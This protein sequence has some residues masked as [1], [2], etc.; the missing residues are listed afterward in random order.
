MS[1]QN[2]A[3]LPKESSFIERLAHQLGTTANA[4][5]IYGEPVE[6]DGVTV[7]PVAKAA[8]GFGGGSG[9]QEK[10]EGAG[11]GGGV[12]LTPVGYIEINNGETRFR[13]TRDP[14]AL[15][16]TILATAPLSLLMV[17]KITKLLRRKDLK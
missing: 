2:E 14:L 1:G 16:A 3:L 4:K 6:R 5:C 9:K 13:P 10:G 17:W 7:I 15:V 11:G 12:M 8:Y